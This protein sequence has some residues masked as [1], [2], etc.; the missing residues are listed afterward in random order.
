MMGFRLSVG[1]A[2][3]ILACLVASLHAQEPVDPTQVYGK[4]F[5][6][7]WV[8]PRYPDGA[9]KEK[10][11]G[12]AQI[13][14][15]VDETGKVATSRI[16]DATDGQFADAAQQAVRQW[17]FTPAIEAGKPAKCS[18][19]TLVVF[20]PDNPSPSGNLPPQDQMP[21]LSP[22][23]DAVLESSPDINY[24]DSLFD[25]KLSGRA[26]YFCDVSA[27]GTVS[28]PRITAATHV[29]FVLPALQAIETLK[30][31][32][33]KQGDQP[34]ESQVEGDIRFDINRQNATGVLAAN[35][36]SAPDGSVPLADIVPITIADPV[37]PY[38]LRLAGKGGTA[39]VLFTV[40]VNGAPKSV[41][42]A[43]A[44]EPEIGAALVA[45]VELCYFSAPAVDG[46]SQ[47]TQLMRSV[48]FTVPDGP[49]AP[50]DP[51]AP[52]VAEAKAGTVPGATGLDARLTPI[53][54]ASPVYPAAVRMMGMPAGKAVIEFIIDHEGRVRLPR[55][56]SATHEEF[57]WAAATAI[58]QWVFEVP[59]RKG[60]PTEVRVQVPFQ[61][62]APTI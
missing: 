30:Y 52:L 40:D 28:K 18:L 27:D 43:G 38:D 3:L 23:T 19:D 61:F 6:R 5:L 37:W 32:P 55:I 59:R 16:L 35:S 25:R 10:T 7:T 56:V 53:F 45:A 42:V 14:L 58:S 8:P 21:D 11:P 60:Q 12:T 26:H 57:G 22:T 31:T 1:R 2:G 33:R 39:S 48:S 20:S 9:L 47:P 36:I 46:R 62:K 15:I 29:D 50:A 49:D 51:L 54:R 41:K 44:S 17:V 24:P 34:L 4:A 13:R